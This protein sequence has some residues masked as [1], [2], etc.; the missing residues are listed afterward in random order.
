MAELLGVPEN[1]AKSYLHRARHLLNGMLKERGI[2]VTDPV[3]EMDSR[4]AGI[5]RLFRQFDGRACPKP[6]AG[7]RPRV[8]RKVRR[9]SE[10]LDRYRQILL[11][12]YVL[13]SVLVSAVIM[14]SQGLGWGPI[15]GSVAWTTGTG[16]GHTLGAACK[17]CGRRR[18]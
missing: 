12:G 17:A 16:R 4:E 8:M 5:D 10:P 3:N 6:A 1:T 11:A 18:R 2:P 14:R 15:A 7:L 9:S 13:I